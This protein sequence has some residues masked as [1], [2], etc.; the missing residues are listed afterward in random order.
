MF[1]PDL[2]VLLYAT[3]RASAHHDACRRWLEEALE[4]DA[5]VGLSW[6]VLQRSLRS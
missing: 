4:G 1:V 3:D 2:N 5:P 6:T